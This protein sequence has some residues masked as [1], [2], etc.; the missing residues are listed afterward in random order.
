[1]RRHCSS[2]R[3]TRHKQLVP[4]HPS[5]H[6]S[7]TDQD[8]TVIFNRLL[9]TEV[10][11]ESKGQRTNWTVHNHIL[12]TTDSQHDAFSAPLA[13]SE[14]AQYVAERGIAQVSLCKI[15]LQR[16]YCNLFGGAPNTLRRHRAALGIAPIVWE[17][18]MGGVSGRGGFAIVG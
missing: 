6:Q 16:G 14:F 8:D 18:R 7:A 9:L 1:M 13:R 15:K 2:L 17:S 10:P 12:L 3:R 5:H 11:V 4:R